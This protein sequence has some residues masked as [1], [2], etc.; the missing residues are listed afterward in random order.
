MS[1]ELF[2]DIV[3]QLAQMRFR[4]R[5]SPHFFGE[6]LLDK[7]LPHLV[8]IVRD[9]L[10]RA[11][12]VIYTNGDLL[13]PERAHALL[14][15]GVA[16]FIVTFEEGET[17]AWRKTEPTLSRAQRR[18]FWVRDFET[19]VSNP[20]NRGGLVRFPTRELH[21]TACYAPASALVVDAWGKVRLCA[22][23]YYG[24]VEWGDLHH[25]RLEEVWARP[26]FRALRRDLL[27]GEFRKPICRACVGLE[28]REPL[29]VNP[30][31]AAR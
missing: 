4:G 26:Q 12:V 14:D 28:E 7:R 31:R 10:P 30:P 1:E 27:R 22:N 16:Y 21:Q 9:R 5:F 23:D 20:F 6:P 15:A 25:D 2:T 24:E 13:T 18:R 11:K 19:G 17:D 29:A 8:S 3:D